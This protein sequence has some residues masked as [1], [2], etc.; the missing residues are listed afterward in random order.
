MAQTRLYERASAASRLT[1]SKTKQETLSD[2]HSHISGQE[3]EGEAE[4]FFDIEGAIKRRDEERMFQKEFAKDL[5][6]L[7]KAKQNDQEEEKGEAATDNHLA[8][9]TKAQ[10]RGKEKV[11][12]KFLAGDLSI[13]DYA[14]HIDQKRSKNTRGHK[15]QNMNKTVDPR[16]QKSMKRLSEFFAGTN[17]ESKNGGLIVNTVIPPRKGELKMSL[18]DIL[19]DLDE[20]A[21]HIENQVALEEIKEQRANQADQ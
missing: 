18:N 9:M 15:R 10:P 3:S 6:K 7:E 13:D 17:E 11:L 8:L 14:Q 21:S 19:A 4:Q 2:A 20:P 1:A 16:S 5:R 12:N